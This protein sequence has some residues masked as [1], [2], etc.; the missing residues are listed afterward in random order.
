MLQKVVEKL[1]EQP[2]LL[3]EFKKGKLNFGISETEK[4][5]V[6]DVLGKEDVQGIDVQ[7]CYWQ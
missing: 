1:I 4:A 7:K 2:N 5:A 6:L 3:E